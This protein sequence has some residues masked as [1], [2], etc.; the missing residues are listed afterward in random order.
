MEEE[1]E[2]PK[3]TVKILYKRFRLSEGLINGNGGG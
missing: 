3:K 1:E 2:D